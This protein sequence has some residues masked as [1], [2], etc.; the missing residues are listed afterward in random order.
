M[1]GLAGFALLLV[2]FGWIPNAG[3]DVLTMDFFSNT[4][5]GGLIKTTSTDLPTCYPTAY[6]SFFQMD[7]ATVK[8]CIASASD[9]G[10]AFA[11]HFNPANL[12]ASLKFDVQGQLVAQTLYNG[13]GCSLNVLSATP[14]TL[15]SCVAIKTPLSSNLD[16]LSSFSNVTK[17]VVP[18][19]APGSSTAGGGSGS[20]SANS[21]TELVG[22]LVH[23]VF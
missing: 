3:A 14:V 1:G 10:Q 9:P 4:T 19:P 12:T 21:A 22:D 17:T 7:C 15:G 20:S 16:C 8:A 13:T 5:C 11:C 23:L 2:L 6:G 18:V